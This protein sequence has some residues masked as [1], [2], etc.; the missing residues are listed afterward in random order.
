MPLLLIL[1]GTT[2]V[3]LRKKVLELV[4]KDFFSSVQN[5]A[6]AKIAAAENTEHKYLMT[7]PQ[8]IKIKTFNKVPGTYI[9]LLQC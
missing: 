5:S 4:Q 8:L 3:L 1:F 9:Q 7:I 6:T 2:I